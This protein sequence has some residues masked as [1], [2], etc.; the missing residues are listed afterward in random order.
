[1]LRDKPDD[2]FVAVAPAPDLFRRHCHSPRAAANGWRARALFCMVH[3]IDY[4]D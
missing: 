2:A 3:G 1:M 4:E